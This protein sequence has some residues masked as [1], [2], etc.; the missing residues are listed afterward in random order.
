[1]YAQLGIEVREI[2]RTRPQAAYTQPVWW[3]PFCDCGNQFL[4]DMSTGGAKP[5]AKCGALVLLSKP[6]PVLT[7]ENLSTAVEAIRDAPMERLPDTPE[8]AGITTAEV[9]EAPPIEAAP[10]PEPPA[11]APRRVARQ[12]IG[13]KKKR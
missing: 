2:I 1:M 3:C 10:E 13:E 9:V 7:T 6:E 4:Q 12:K 8:E 5:C 11:Q